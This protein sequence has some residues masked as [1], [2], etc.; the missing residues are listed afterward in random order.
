MSV[1]ISEQD[2]LDRDE[3]IEELERERERAEWLITN[4]QNAVDAYVDRVL[5]L[6]GILARERQCSTCCGTPHASG[7]PCI[8]GG[9]NRA[10]DEVKNLRLESMVL[11]DAVTRMGEELKYKHDPEFQGALIAWRGLTEEEREE[12]IRS[13]ESIA[14]GNALGAAVRGRSIYNPAQIA[15]RLLKAAAR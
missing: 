15:A 1:G 10:E 11:R 3:R 4:K 2:I 12:A 5:L 6:E 14:M 13:N 9:T 7:L 8:C